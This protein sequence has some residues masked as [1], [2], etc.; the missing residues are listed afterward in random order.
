MLGRKSV[1]GKVEIAVLVPNAVS[2][3]VHNTGYTHACTSMAI[4]AYICAFMPINGR[5]IYVEHIYSRWSCVI[6][7]PHDWCL[8]FYFNVIVMIAIC[9]NAKEAPAQT[10]P[11]TAMTRENTA[12]LA[13]IKLQPTSAKQSTEVVA[14]CLQACQNLDKWTWKQKCS[15]RSGDC[16]ACPQCSEWARERMYMCMCELLHR[17]IVFSNCV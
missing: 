10:T 11:I 13:T 9:R 6:T 4:R 1:H 3:F 12:E 14:R 5:R 7:S 8:F 2:D 16:K 15:W 17:T